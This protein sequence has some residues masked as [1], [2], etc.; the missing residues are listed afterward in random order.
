MLCETRGLYDNFKLIAR[1]DNMLKTANHI[2]YGFEWFGIP[3]TEWM[4]LVMAIIGTFFAI[5][6]YL[7]LIKD[8]KRQH[9]RIIQQ[10]YESIFYNLL[11]IHYELLNNLYY[12]TEP[13]YEN[14]G[15]VIREAVIY[16]GREYLELIRHDLEWDFS[17]DCIGVY[18]DKQ[19][20]NELATKVSKEIFKE[21]DNLISSFINNI[22][23]VFETVERFGTSYEL[24]IFYA[25]IYRNQLS[26]T[27]RFILQNHNLINT[28]LEQTKLYKSFNIGGNHIEFNEV[29]R[30]RKIID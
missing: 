16:K 10:Q 7:R 13:L 19:K 15:K 21:N 25:D 23:A 28:N 5:K 22:Y 8:D 3:V 17:K 11:K 1:N 24:K 18:N 20:V 6:G 4:I 2:W 14:D 30:R 27:E 26:Q 9:E 12:I 29:L